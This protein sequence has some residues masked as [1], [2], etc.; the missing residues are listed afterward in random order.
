MERSDRGIRGNRGRLPFHIALKADSLPQ[1]KIQQPPD[2]V[3][4]IAVCRSDARAKM[5][6][7]GLGTEQSAA[8]AS[9]SVNSVSRSAAIAVPPANKPKASGIPSSGGR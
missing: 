9:G 6:A 3:A 7:D 5:R 4:M 1:L 2:T 8:S